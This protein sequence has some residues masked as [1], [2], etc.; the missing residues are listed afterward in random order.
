MS[1]AVWAYSLISV[2]IVSLVSLV[3]VFT[4]GLK[5]IA[6]NRVLLFFV[7][8]A[9]GGMFGGAFFHLIPEAAESHSF[10]FVG[11]CILSGL[12]AFFVLEKFIH[13][14]HCHVPTSK[15]H[16]H[17]MGMM[18]IVGDGFHNFID[19]MV[20]GG[21]YLVSTGLGVTTTFAILIHEVPQ[22][23]GDFGVLLHAGYK[24]KKALLLNFLSA[25]TAILGVV[26]S[27]VIGTRVEWFTPFL[28]P[29]TAGGFIYIAGSDLIPE[30]H[31]ECGA[32]RSFFQFIALVMGMA[33]MLAL[34]LLE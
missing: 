26:V 16:P 12:L 8:F 23:I 18:N 25:C 24:K 4:I 14:R 10:S 3:G 13:W 1:V 17:P 31:K 9:A 19:G 22:E 33:A 2:I 11:A 6:L 20:M 5:D 21:A 7:S 28:I 30:L 32:S 27:L 29:F 34:T 15:G